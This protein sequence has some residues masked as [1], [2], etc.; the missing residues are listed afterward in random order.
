MSKIKSRNQSITKYLQKLPILQTNVVLFFVKTK[1]ILRSF[2]VC[3]N[4]Q[5][6][7]DDGLKR[8][9]QSDVIMGEKTTA[10]YSLKDREDPLSAKA[11]IEHYLTL[12][13]GSNS[14]NGAETTKSEIKTQSVMT[15]DMDNFHLEENLK[16]CLNGELFYENSWKQSVP[17]IFS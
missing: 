17:R 2:F 4:L 10:T 5:I 3:R 12:N 16:V 15:S 11:E 6:I 13:F 7:E 14:S 8:H 9:V 1:C